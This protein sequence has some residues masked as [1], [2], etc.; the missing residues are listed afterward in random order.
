MSQNTARIISLVPSWTETLLE[1]GLNVVGRTRFCIYP[2][3][4]VQTI[5]II[6]GTKGIHLQKL[7][8]LKPDFVVLD[9][10]E[11]RK[12]MAEQ[13]QSAGVKVLV[14]HVDSLESAAAFLS[15]VSPL[16]KAPKLQGYAERYRSIRSLDAQ[17]FSQHVLLQGKWKDFSTGPFQYV[18][19]KDPFMVIGNNTFISEVLARVGLQVLPSEKYPQIEVEELKKY[20][21]LFSSEP[22]PF[23]REF[24]KLESEGFQGVVVDGEKISWY[25]IRNL[26]FLESCAI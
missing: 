10:E 23:Q 11:N 2:H 9:K 13:L 14:S 3:E 1:V 18:I 15:E 26:I 25:G 8:E 21:C 24:L 6:G 22:Y 4:K 7:L 17:K 12:E 19:W 5:P 20:F 16:F